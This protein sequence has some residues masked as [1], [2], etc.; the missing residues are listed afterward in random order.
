MREKL[1][2]E[3]PVAKEGHD[4]ERVSTLRLILAAV[5]DRDASVRSE[6]NTKGVSDEQIVKL[7][8]Q[9]IVQRNKSALHYNESGRLEDAEREESEIMVIREFLPKRLSEEEMIKLVETV[10]AK[11]KA[12]SIRQLGKVVNALKKNYSDQLDFSKAVTVVKS[13][14]LGQQ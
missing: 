11:E 3:L 2:L 8:N 14:L 5:R 4:K 9:M 1:N 13:L 10:I 12:V 7:L 6:E